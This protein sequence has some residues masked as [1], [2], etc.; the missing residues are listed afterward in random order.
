MSEHRSK[1]MSKHMPAHRY[2]NWSDCRTHMLV[3]NTCGFE[4]GVYGKP[5]IQD[6]ATKA[7]QL[8]AATARYR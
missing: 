3:N 7:A 6:S 4:V 8:V 5:R 1:R 2:N